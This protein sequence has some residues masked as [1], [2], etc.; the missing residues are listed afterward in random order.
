M[1]RMSWFWFLIGAIAG[2]FA[3]PRLLGLVSR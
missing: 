3:V 1:P 2:W